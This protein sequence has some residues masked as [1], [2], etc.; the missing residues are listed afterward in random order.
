MRSPVYHRLYSSFLLCLSRLD[1]AG[2]RSALS[3]GSSWRTGTRCSDRTHSTR[4][5]LLV[6]IDEEDWTLVQLWLSC[7]DFRRS[8]VPENIVRKTLLHRYRVFYVFKYSQFSRSLTV[9]VLEIRITLGP[10]RTTSTRKGI[11]REGTS[12]FEANA[13]ALNIQ[14]MEYR[15]NSYATIDK[16][17]NGLTNAAHELILLSRRGHRK[18]YE[19]LRER[20]LYVPWFQYIC[21]D[22]IGNTP[23]NFRLIL[24]VFQVEIF[25]ASCIFSFFSFFFWTLHKNQPTKSIFECCAMLELSKEQL[26]FSIFSSSILKKSSWLVDISL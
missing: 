1:S 8:L 24:I 22:T 4:L 23:C 20:L 7:P 10:S 6:P 19:A 16:T 2:T 13:R 3:H 11:E 18:V 15:T 5:R 17:F 14:P 9:S 26:T 21:I 12:I 25:I